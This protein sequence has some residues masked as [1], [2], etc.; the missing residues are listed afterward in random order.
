MANLNYADGEL[1]L[2]I[3]YYGCGLGGKTTN[4]RSIYAALDSKKRVS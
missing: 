4:L 1:N 3:V 2:K